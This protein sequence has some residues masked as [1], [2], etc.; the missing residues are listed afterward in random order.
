MT[1]LPLGSLA[2]LL[3]GS[4]DSTKQGTEWCAYSDEYPLSFCQAATLFSTMGMMVKGG[5]ELEVPL[6]DPVQEDFLCD[7]LEPL[8]DNDLDALKNI[9]TTVD[10]V[11]FSNLVDSFKTAVETPAVTITD[12]KIKT[13]LMSCC[14]LYTSDAADE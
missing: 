13:D 14:L 3:K 11:G 12:Y 8:G 10:Y 5:L 7:I 1:N 2:P 9:T 6:C 4:L